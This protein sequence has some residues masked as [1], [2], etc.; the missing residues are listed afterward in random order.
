MTPQPKPGS[1]LAEEVVL[2][3]EAVA[4]HAGPW[5][6]RVAVAPAE[7]DQDGE[8]PEDWVPPPLGPLLALLRGQPNEQAARYLDRAADLVALLRAVLADRWEPE[9]IHMPGFR[10]HH[11]SAAGSPRVQRIPLR[12]GFGATDT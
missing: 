9:V 12:P 7:H 5:L 6:D 10:P 3:I 8:H 1:R 2:L 11:H 4:E